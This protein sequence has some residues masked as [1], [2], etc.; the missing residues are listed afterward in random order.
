[1]SNVKEATVDNLTSSQLIELSEKEVAE[2]GERKQSPLRQKREDQWKTVDEQVELSKVTKHAILPDWYPDTPIPSQANALEVLGT[3]VDRLQFPTSHEFFSVDVEMT[4]EY[5]KRIEKDVQ[6]IGS[7]IGRVDFDQE[8]LNAVTQA[9]LIHA[10]K[11]YDFRD[12]NAQI[13]AE[14]LCYGSYCGRLISTK[15]STFTNSFRGVGRT[16]STLPVLLPLSIKNVYLDEKSVNSINQG[17][18]IGSR[19]MYTYKQRLSDLKLAAKKGG[20]DTRDMAGG[21]LTSVINEIESPSKSGDMIELLEVEGDILIPNGNNDDIFVPNLIVTHAIS[22]GGPRV[23]RIRENSLPFSPL[24][25]GTYFKG[26]IKTY[27]TSPLIKGSPI[28]SAAHDMMNAMQATAWLT[29]GPP[30]GWNK[31]DFALRAA[32]GPAVHPFA[33]WDTMSDVKVH[34]MGSIADVKDTYFALVK[35]YEETTGVTSP[36]TGAQTKSHQTAYAVNS[37]VNQGQSRTVGFVSSKSRGFM[38]DVLNGELAILRKDMKR[39]SVYVPRMKMYVSITGNSLPDSATFEVRGAGNPQAEAQERQVKVAVLAQLLKLEATGVTEKLGGKPLDIDAV[40]E[41][42]L[43]EGVP[44][45]E[46]PRFFKDAASSQQP[47]QGG[48]PGVPGGNPPGDVQAVAQNLGF[49]NG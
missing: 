6:F 22:K 47:L 25:H 7:D 37:E 23:V 2:L 11:Q 21:Y 14:A 46:I 34:E 18:E 42:L 31:N 33:L 19:Q 10:H 13:D 41:E 3:D 35:Q 27:G 9:A 39:H 38:T 44:E 49:E 5:L 8:D 12:H 1:M 28:H 45:T 20:S 17:V 36:R 29:A 48:I 32:G 43:K 40:R 16:D 24:M 4:E 30:V 15:R 26:G